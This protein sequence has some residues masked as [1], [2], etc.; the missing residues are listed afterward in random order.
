MNER[1]L[2]DT[3]EKALSEVK[4]ILGLSSGFCREYLRAFGAL[5]EKLPQQTIHRDPNPGNIICCGE[6]YGFIDFELSEC[7]VRIYDPCY[8]ATAILSE[9]FG[10]DN[11][12]WLEICRNIILGYDSVVNLSEEERRAVPY[13]ILANQLLCTSWFAGKEKYAALFETNIRMTLWLIEVFDRL[14]VEI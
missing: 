6:Q 12:K 5:Y 4:E 8:A 9:T 2:L 3:A 10:N 13:V 11:E 14:A 7:C 1:N